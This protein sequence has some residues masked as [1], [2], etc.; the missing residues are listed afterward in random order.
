M[1]ALHRKMEKRKRKLVE[2]AYI[3]TSLVTLVAS[4]CKPISVSSQTHANG[5]ISAL[6][7]KTFAQVFH[8][9]C[10]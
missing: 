3:A 4:V 5:P 6:P 8:I 9:E 1:T 10:I 2:A 7:W